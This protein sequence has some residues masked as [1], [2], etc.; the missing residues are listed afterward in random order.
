VFSRVA[1]FTIQQTFTSL[2]RTVGTFIVPSAFEALRKPNHAADNS[3]KRARIS[4]LL[5]IKAQLYFSFCAA[6]LAL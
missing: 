3:R 4:D 5:G 2:E 1:L 6:L